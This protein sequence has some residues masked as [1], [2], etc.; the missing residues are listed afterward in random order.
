MY[1]HRQGLSVSP[2]PPSHQAGPSGPSQPPWMTQQG[3]A[4]S[5]AFPIGRTGPQL[6][7][8][9]PSQPHLQPSPQ[10]HSATQMSQNNPQ[11]PG[12][13]S[14]QL[15]PAQLPN[16]ISP[17][18]SNQFPGNQ[19]PTQNGQ[20]IS[21]FTLP[22]PLDKS[23]FEESYAAFCNSR[24]M[25]RDE[26]LMQVDNRPVDLH[27][28]HYNVMLEGGAT[29]VSTSAIYSRFVTNKVLQ[30]TQRDMWSVIG[31][32]M[33]FVQFPGTDTEP[34]KSGPGVAQQL[35]HIHSEYLLQFDKIYVHSVLQKKGLFSSQTSN[36]TGGGSQGN[37]HPASSP[38]VNNVSVP[39]QGNSGPTGNMSGANQVG[40]V[41]HQGFCLSMILIHQKMNA[42]IM[43]ANISAADL[44]ARNIPEQVIH[45]VEM[46]RAHLQR[47]SQQQQMFRG[48]VQKPTISGQASEQGRNTDVL[49][50]FP[51]MLQHA[52]RPPPAQGHPA[53]G[54]NISGANNGQQKPPP[55]GVP[56]NMAV[57]RPARPTPEQ[58]HEALQ[59]IQRIKTE[60]VT[61]SEY[62]ALGRFLTRKTDAPIDL[63]AM[64][65]HQVPETQRGDYG[66]I[67]EQAYRHA[68][69]VEPKLPMY[70]Y[71]LKD[72]DMVRKLIAI[73]R[74]IYTF[75]L[76]VH[77]SSFIL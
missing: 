16:Q 51:N 64:K 56:P 23:K 11:R 57:S 70:Y 34:A 60:F 44:R 48:I 38:Q 43:Y 10:L 54:M 69:E 42:V 49:G 28:L 71:V 18:L 24:S 62:L 46:H 3:S 37:N 32:R 6:P 15:M 50:P 7:A 27:A 72:Q 59:F 68:Q 61:K 25:M 45:F 55:N 41:R 8:R 33:G 1:S 40:M 39:P 2:G 67:L 14:R 5:Q 26:R 12:S 75:N 52:S 77:R 76:L 58:S 47:T 35:Q 30:V 19:F 29:K 66:R 74:V 22:P 21:Q 36:S 53:A 63:P 65:Q 17:N 9:G 20:N 31:A 13:T 4:Q 73:V